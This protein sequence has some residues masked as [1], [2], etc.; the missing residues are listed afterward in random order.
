M[1]NHSDRYQV[2]PFPKMRRFVTDFGWVSRRRHIIRGLVEVDVTDARRVLQDHKRRTGESIS[3]TAFVTACLGQAVAADRRVQALRDWRGRL[4]IFDDVDQAG[5]T[6]TIQNCTF[7]DNTVLSDGGGIYNYIGSATV[8]NSTFSGNTADGAGGA[9]YNLDTLHLVN[10]ILA[11][12][13]C[14]T[15]CTNLGTLATNL[16]NLVEDEL[17]C[18]GA[19]TGDPNLDPLANNGGPTHTMA[20]HLGSPAIIA[21][22][23]AGAAGLTTDQRG[24]G[25]PRIRGLI[26]D[27]GAFERCILSGDVNADGIVNVLDLQLIASAWLTSNPVYDINA[28]GRVDILDIMIAAGEF[29]QGC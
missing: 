17:D 23:N 10:T 16:T 25:Y 4:F 2:M 22:S 7:F 18:P 20:L 29:G 13:N 9:L 11:N 28:S 26:V 3:F 21:G 8:V 6:A 15:D 19:L 14:T 1:T 24:T 27:I 5:G 12:S